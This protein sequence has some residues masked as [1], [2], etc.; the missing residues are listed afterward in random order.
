MVHVHPAG[1]SHPPG[2]SHLPGHDHPHG[3]EH[4]PGASAARQRRLGWVLGLTATFMVAEVVGGALSNSLALLADAGHMFTDVAALA[5]SLFAIGMARR[6]PSP[7]K[8]YGY[9][10]LEILAALVNGAALLAI[11]GVIVWEAG[12]RLGEPVSVDAPLLI[13][14]SLAG[15]LINVV[16]AALLHAHARESLNVRGAYLHV[17]GDL[18]G[19]LGALTA[20][21]IIL[22]TGWTAADAIVSV[23]IALLIL[24]N[25]WRLVREAADVL[26][27]AAPP[28]IDVS[29]VLAALKA[30]PGL[31]D[32]HD[33]HVWT[34]TSGFV[35]LS[36]HGVLDDPAS[37]R[38]VLANIQVCL[39]RFGIEHVT[40]QLEPRQPLAESEIAA[41]AD[42]PWDRSQKS[43]RI[44]LITVMNTRKIAGTNA[45]PTENVRPM[46]YRAG[47]MGS[48]D[49]P[50]ILCAR[51]STVGPSK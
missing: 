15:L 39:R 30:V 47:P 31:D 35:A 40:F 4:D 29:E 19:S 13:G 45:R 20:G 7:T 43:D 10:R 5:L 37:Y 46:R 49:R 24:V 44:T 28:H 8:T 18:L 26:L 36:G 11:A 41:R 22:I 48:S 9:V 38:D 12:R 17:L 14:V 2:H 23:L 27:E 6:A 34:L 32:V 21:A 33:L 16:S 50:Q 51:I 3:H 42:E 1:H 25:A